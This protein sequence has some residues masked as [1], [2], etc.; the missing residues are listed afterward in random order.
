MYEQVYLPSVTVIATAQVWK[1]VIGSGYQPYDDIR[2]K[3]IES[4]TIPNARTNI[5]AW[6]DSMIGYELLDLSIELQPN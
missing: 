6:I 3:R 5:Q 2:R 4:D 1:I